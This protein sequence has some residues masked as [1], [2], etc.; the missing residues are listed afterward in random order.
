MLTP[1]EWLVYPQ[2][3]Y[4]MMRKIEGLYMTQWRYALL[5]LL[6]AANTTYAVDGYKDLKFGMAKEQFVATKTCTL[7]DG[8]RNDAVSVLFCEDFRFGKSDIEAGF[9]FINER[10]EGLTLYIGVDNFLG[11]ASSLKQKYGKVSSS[12]TK[13]EFEVFDHS[14][15][16]SVFVAFAQDTVRLMATS[17]E[18]GEQDATLSYLSDT[19]IKKMASAQASEVE[20]DL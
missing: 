1:D 9:Y 2:S 16:G 10:L 11:I 19:Y 5:V 17:D 3:D 12:S 6:A 7:Q 8:D 4:P 18:A 14:G 15:A 20:K 13:K